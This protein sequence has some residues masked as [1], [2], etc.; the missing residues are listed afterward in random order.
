MLMLQILI[1]GNVFLKL[2]RLGCLLLFVMMKLPR[3]KETR[4]FIEFLP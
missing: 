4:K 3:I 1:K 2:I